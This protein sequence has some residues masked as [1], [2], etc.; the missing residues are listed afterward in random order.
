MGYKGADY[1]ISKRDNF[2]SLG[3][4]PSRITTAETASCN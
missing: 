3:T 1:N 4:P 2:T